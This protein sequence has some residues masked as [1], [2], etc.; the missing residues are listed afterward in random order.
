MDARFT[1]G[2]KRDVAGQGCHLDL[3]V[4]GDRAILFGFHSKNASFTLLK[5][6]IAVSW[7][8]PTRSRVAKFLQHVHGLIAAVKDDGKRALAQSA[9]KQF[10]SH[11]SLQ[12]PI[13][14]R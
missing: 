6:P 12:G 2:T 8:P 10:T 9:M 4:D 5:A 1:I 7:A 13:L 3:F 11:V 14:L